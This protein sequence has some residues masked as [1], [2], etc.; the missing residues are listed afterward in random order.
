MTL[1]E[2]RRHFPHTEQMI[3]MN[4]AATAPLSRP[5]IE[6][7]DRYLE[8]RHR[9]RVENYTDVLPVVAE[10]KARLAE[11]L[12]THPARVEFAAN[13]SA[14]LNVLAEGLDWQ[15]GDRIALPGCEFP[16]NVY[17][18][19][20]QRRRGVEVDVIPHDRGIVTLDAI[21]RTL[22][23]RTRLLTLSWV[24][25]L[26]GYRVDLD[27]VGRL[28]RSKGVLLCVDAIQGLGALRLD[29][30][31][32]GVDFLACGAQKWLMGTQGLGFIYVTEALQER[33]TPVAGWLHGPVDWDD[34]FDYELRFH[35]DA[36]R[37][38]L[39]TLNHLGVVALHAALGLY[40]EAGPAWCEAQVLDRA[41]SLAAGLEQ[42][43][44]ERYGSTDPD[45]TSGIVTFELAAPDALLAHLG[46]HGMCASV[47]NRKLRFAPT[48]YNTPEEVARVVEEVAA[49]GTTRA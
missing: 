22:T 10:T 9:T 17:P 3:Y 29:V 35:P 12:G 11:L 32:S 13:T 23:P 43:G 2:L 24:Q 19:M 33:L 6:A 1:D 20:N 48:Y 42:L 18:F 15:P 26:S 14:G 31:A 34:F 41:R 27:A 28:C 21:E 8:Q 16:A 36:S 46:R 30:E 5:V 44:L 37:F 38:R 4:H 39:G 45:H 25:F 40:L 47:R 49:F 7:L